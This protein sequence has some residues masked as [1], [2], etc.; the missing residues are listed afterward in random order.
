MKYNV[1]SSCMLFRLHQTAAKGLCASVKVKSKN[2]AVC[3][4]TIIH[5][6][7]H[8]CYNST[9]R[10]QPVRRINYFLEEPWT[11]IKRKNNAF[12]KRLPFKTY[13]QVSDKTIGLCITKQYRN[14]WL[15]QQANSTGPST[16]GGRRKDTAVPRIVLQQT[17][18]QATRNSRLD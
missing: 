10:Q 13:N 5:T 9:F 16:S 1:F 3:I 14:Y 7:H 18:L 15:L 11:Y 6:G 4:L 8:I 12:F 2:R 17:S